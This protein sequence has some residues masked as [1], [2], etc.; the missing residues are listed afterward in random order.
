M[1]SPDQSIGVFTAD[2]SLKLVSWDSW[3]VRA[4]GIAESAAIG[5]P[6]TEIIPNLESRG[7]LRR[8]ETVLADG[9]V[10]ML[11]PTFHH[12]LMPCPPRE[13]SEHFDRMQQA[14]TIAPLHQGERIAGV[15]VTIEDVTARLDEERTLAANLK[16]S[17]EIERI[18]STQAL[19]DRESL[20]STE[21]L[22]SVIGD[23]SWR[24]RREA[25][26]G[27]ARHAEPEAIAGL[28][29][30]LKD[31][32]RNL[33]ILNSALQVLT[34]SNV[35]V[36][37]PLIG[38]LS[39]PDA[40]LRSQAAL[41]LGEQHD[42]RAVPGLL[43]AVNDVDANVQYHAIEALGKLRAIEAIDALTAMAESRDFFLAFPSLDAL[44]R[45]G[46][47]REAPRLVPLLQDELLRGAATDALG[48]LGSETAVEPLIELL[49][50]E[51]A[52]G[53]AIA[54]ALATLSGRYEENYG[55]GTYIADLVHS[56]I[57]QSG[58]KHMLDALND[59]NPDELRSLATVLGWLDGPQVE[60]AM[61][62][63]LSRPTARK[64]VVEALVRYGQRVTGLLTEQLGSA[65]IETR[66]AAVIALGRIGDPKAVPDLIRFLTSDPDLLIVTAG[67]LAKIGDRQSFDVLLTLLDH[68]DAAVRQS[69]IAALNSLGHPGMEARV[70]AMLSDPKPVI[71]ESAV[72]IAGYFG[73]E[74]CIDLVLERC[75]DENEMVRRAAIEHI[76]YIDDDRVLPT[77]IEALQTPAP[78]VRAAAAHAMANVESPGIFSHLI[79]ALN[80]VDAWVRYFAIRSIGRHGYTE[81]IDVLASK[82][83]LDPAIHVRVA[84]LEALGS[85]GGARA[86]AII[87]PWAENDNDDLAR[88]ALNALGL[89]GHPD[90]LSPLQAALR[91]PLL[92]RRIDAVQALGKRGGIGAVGALQWVVAADSDS[93][94]AK[95]AIEAL[96][97]LRTPEGIAALVALTS[98]PTR[99]ESCI[100]TLAQMDE[101]QIESIARG[102]GHP[103]PQVRHAV[104]TALGRMRYL[105]VPE[106]LSTGLKDS[107]PS[108]RL[109]SIAALEH[110]GTRREDRKL[111]TLASTDPD[112]RVRDAAQ[113]AL[114][115]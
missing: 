5:K 63:L 8:F 36:I 40:E 100:A 96:A 95:S 99:R 105:G 101:S 78:R 54:N 1:T 49:N 18:K 10:Q 90:A 39:E 12:Y 104:I 38:F 9:L 64:E 13:P 41:A 37:S 91:S 19:A 67:A 15:I 70:Y 16:R 84:A 2:V 46:D 92:N 25:V 77:L 45:I 48:L 7:L 71:R 66:R 51:S 74:K 11:A 97:R 103:N 56:K 29:R 113:R 23:G 86:V 102:L 53:R 81:A 75:R 115:K 3:L 47:S 24:V 80:D 27:L 60:R 28:L 50:K 57:N 94:V 65:D 59:A 108:V 58:T 82:A 31:E 52:P 6:L 69:V 22:V 14:V 114:R 21:P 4:T 85:I 34:L 33:S 17:D 30:L 61:V 68:P 73:F 98:D 110:L 20:A 88:A 83:K 32:H 44:M 109:A 89:I 72:K 43:A 55:E 79:G 106:L 62:D 76:P 26:I 107:D 42:A 111:A 35:D 112:V 93:Q 87:A